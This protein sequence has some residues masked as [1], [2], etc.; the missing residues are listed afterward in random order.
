MSNRLK[1]GL[2]GAGIFAGYHANKL[3]A[4]PRVDFIGVMDRGAPAA[5]ALAKKHDIKAM[6][7][8]E[9]LEKSDAVVIAS[10]ATTHGS[11]AAQVLQAGCHCLIEK[12]MTTTSEAADQIVSLA[13]SKNL[14]VQVGH[15]ERLILRATG[16]VDVKE[17][18]TR[19]VAFRYSP[20]TPRGTDTSVTLDLMTHD[21]DLCTAL[22]GETP[23]AIEGRA[24]CETGEQ[25]DHS[26]ARLTYSGLTANLAASRIK[27]ES[28]RRMQITYP[29]GIVD[30]DFNTKTL[31]HTTPFDL[32]ENFA[33]DD[34][35]KD[36]LAA[37]TDIFIRAVLDGSPV[38]V[39]A[40]DGALA[41]RTAI[42]IDAAG[43]R[44]NEGKT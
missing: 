3:A 10:P 29:S 28:F 31:A 22:I 12:P 24:S 20:F 6:A 8:K 44:F 36:S 4:H 41:V 18:P 17:R 21:I 11:I 9:L 33:E 14:I 26:F 37:A 38:L 15:Q 23:I 13:A 43:Q 25:P 32:N 40:E 7:L 5:K 27:K 39:S 42:A 16:L 1:I 30:I 34:I 2:I 35:A 19:I